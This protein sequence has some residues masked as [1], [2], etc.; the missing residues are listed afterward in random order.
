VVAALTA[1]PLTTDEAKAMARLCDEREPYA[2]IGDMVRF[3]PAGWV[4]YPRGDEFLARNHSD[5]DSG[6]VHLTTDEA[7]RLGL[8]KMERKK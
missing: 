7:R 6:D 5:A 4:L 8:V 3:D 1:R 2:E